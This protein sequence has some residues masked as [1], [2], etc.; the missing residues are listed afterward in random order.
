MRIAFDVS[1]LNDPVT[2]T[3]PVVRLRVTWTFPD[4]VLA[5]I[6]TSCELVNVMLK[7]ET[8]ALPR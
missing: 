6:G 1:P 5:F 7:V 2:V 8:L 4:A 3:A